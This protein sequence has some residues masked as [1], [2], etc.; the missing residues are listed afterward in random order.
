M[1]EDKHLMAAI[2]EQADRAERAK[3]SRF[4][5]GALALALSEEFSHWSPNEIAERMDKVWRERGLL[6]A[7]VHL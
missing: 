4:D 3:P 6:F 2:Y 1:R 7:S 5:R